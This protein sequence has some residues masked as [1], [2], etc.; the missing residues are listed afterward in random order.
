MHLFCETAQ[1]KQWQ[2]VVQHVGMSKFALTFLLCIVMF[3]KSPKLLGFEE[4]GTS[5]FGRHILVAKNKSHWSSLLVAYTIL[6]EGT[7]NKP[8]DTLQDRYSLD[9]FHP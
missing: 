2:D 9:F 4:R 6:I 3:S 7:A 8:N 5:P 1:T